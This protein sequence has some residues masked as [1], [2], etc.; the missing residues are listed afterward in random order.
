M[1][2][3][4]SVDV[5]DFLIFL[6]GEG[7]GSEPPRR[8]GTTYLLKIPGGGG[9]VSQAGVGRVFARNFLG[10]GGNFFVGGPKVPPRKGS[11]PLN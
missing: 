8:G 5:S 2:V 6:V 3:E 9:G 10:G 4:N 7:R 1:S 11:S